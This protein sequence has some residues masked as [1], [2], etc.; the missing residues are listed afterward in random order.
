MQVYM[1]VGTCVPCNCELNPDNVVGE[2]SAFESA[3]KRPFVALTTKFNW[4]VPHESTHVILLA[5][6]SINESST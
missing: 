6:R 1:Y 4:A 2:Q 5:P 3:I